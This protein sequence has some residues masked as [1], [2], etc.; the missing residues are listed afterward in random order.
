V[1]SRTIDKA[2]LAGVR[3]LPGLLATRL[4]AGRTQVRVVADA[5]PDPAFEPVTSNLEDV[6]FA[7]L[8]RHRRTGGAGPAAPTA[9]AA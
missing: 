4:R 3:T 9:E 5:A 8:H 7:T 1:W 2:D 6:Y